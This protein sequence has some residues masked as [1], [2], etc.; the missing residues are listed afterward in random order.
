VVTPQKKP[1]G[2]PKKDPDAVA[3]VAAKKGGKRKKAKKPVKPK[4]PGRGRGRPSKNPRPVEEIEMLVEEGDEVEDEK[5]V[6][7]NEKEEKKEDEEEASE[8]E[9]SEASDAEKGE[10]ESSADDRPVAII[11]AALSGRSSRVRKPVERFEAAPASI[12]INGPRKKKLVEGGDQI[13]VVPAKP[14]SKSQKAMDVSGD[15]DEEEMEGKE[16]EDNESEEEEEESAS[17]AESVVVVVKKKNWEDEEDD[18]E[19]E[20]EEEDLYSSGDDDKEKKAMGEEEEEEEGKDK[21]LKSS[22]RVDERETVAT[23]T[24]PDPPPIEPSTSALAY[25]VALD[26]RG[27]TWGLC[28]SPVGASTGTGDVLGALAVVCG[29]GSCLVMVLPKEAG[30]AAADGSFRQAPLLQEDAVCRV[31]I[32]P[33]GGAMVSAACWDPH[34]PHQLLCGLTN[35]TV[36]IWAL[37]QYLC[38]GKLKLLRFV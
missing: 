14:S 30:G 6:G 35:G 29:D 5:E 20:E 3:T 12:F 23:E 26:R 16:E 24:R 18:D 31:E 7:V 10:E 19:E 37:Q 13:E 21:D 32:R 34:R 9:E 17:D 11:Q 33:S 28:W 25:C 4:V 15:E 38:E 8:E 2:R 1:K 27:P 22:R 36:T